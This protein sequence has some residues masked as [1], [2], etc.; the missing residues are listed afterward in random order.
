MSV[1]AY[2]RACV[3]ARARVCSESRMG[4]AEIAGSAWHCHIINFNKMQWAS[5]AGPL[6]TR[7]LRRFFLALRKSSRRP[8]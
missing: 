5:F 3:R 4:A 8:C 2:E 7:T 1:R 6:D